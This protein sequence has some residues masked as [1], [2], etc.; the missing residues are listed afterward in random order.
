MV[1]NSQNI[2][3]ERAWCDNPLPMKGQKVEENMGNPLPVQHSTLKCTST[4][5]SRHML[6]G[7]ASRGQKSQCTYTHKLTLSCSTNMHG[8]KRQEE[9]EEETAKLRQNITNHTHIHTRRTHTSL[10]EDL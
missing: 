3:V 7:N 1:K 10:T 8:R 5:E 2:S 6:K 4:S 9:E